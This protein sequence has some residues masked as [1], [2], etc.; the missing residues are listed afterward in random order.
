MLYSYTHVATVDVK[1]LTVTVKG[2]ERAPLG[3]IPVLN[4]IATSLNLGSMCPGSQTG[5]SDLHWRVFLLD[6][7]LDQLNVL[8]HVENLLQNLQ[9]PNRQVQ[10]YTGFRGR[11]AEYFT[12]FYN[13]MTYD[14][15]VIDSSKQSLNPSGRQLL[16]PYVC[17]YGQLVIGQ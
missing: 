9:T 10:R 15:S 16:H 12:H 5:V 11:H 17:V 6:T 1:W 13:R 4:M 14:F 8:L 2:S 3:A 7:D